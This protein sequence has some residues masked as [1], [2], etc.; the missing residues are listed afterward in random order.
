MG[1]PGSGKGTQAERL[2]SAHGVSRISTGDILREAIKAGTPIAAVAKA[3]M[4][5][6]ELVDDETMIN[7]VRERLVQ[8]DIRRGFVLD[9]FPRTVLQAEALDGM[10]K[11]YQGQPL[12]VVDVMVPHD[13]LVRRLASRR[14][15]SQCGINAA[16]EAETCAKC[17]GLFVQ[18]TDDNRDVVDQRLRV[19]ERVTKPLVDYYRSRS[20]FRVVD[21][22]QSLEEVAKELE[23][24]IAEASEAGVR[25]T[26]ADERGRTD[27]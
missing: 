11:D 14:I 16:L 19:Y 4:D 15:C 20:T 24:V 18:R 17:G 22:A 23:T 21:G 12:V 6:G 27:T 5:R 2:A 8:D 25:T 26:P 3:E 7:I 9:G 1:P 13:E 10:M